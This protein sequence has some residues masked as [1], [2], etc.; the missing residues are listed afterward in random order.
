VGSTRFALAD[1]LWR[2][3]DRDDRMRARVLAGSA[4]QSVLVQ[5]AS[6][7]KG[8]LSGPAAQQAIQARHLD[9][10]IARIDRWRAQHR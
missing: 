1:A 5:Q 3:D 2:R 6:L 10:L 9:E 8:S 7:Q 4:R